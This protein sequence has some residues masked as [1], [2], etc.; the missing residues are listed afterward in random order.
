MRKKINCVIT[1]LDDT[2][3]DWLEMWYN[4]FNPYF[5]NIK[6]KFEKDEKD[7]LNDFKSLHQKYH[8]SEISFAYN[9]LIT[10][11]EEEKRSISEVDNFEKKSIIHQYYSDKKNNLKLYDGVKDT[12]SFLKANG[13]LIIAFTESNAFFTKYRIKQLGLD[14]L[15]DCIYTPLGYGIPESVQRYYEEDYWNPSKTL[16]RHLSNKDKKPNPEILEIII[17]DY[18][19]K[20][21][22]VIYIGDKLDRDIQMALEVGITSIYASYGNMIESYKYELLRNV[23]HWTDEE[24]ERERNIKNSL[25][26][27]KIIPDY[28]ISNYSKILELFEFEQY[29][30]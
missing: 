28:T 1:D 11:N 5:N 9:E 22:E 17:A 15:I 25:S 4:S 19:L 12:L 30:K 14:G 27:K 18:N 6:S 29:I 8:T 16:I 2:L 20:K 7:L 26:T 24:V 13:V 10:L 3:W 21:D 23:T